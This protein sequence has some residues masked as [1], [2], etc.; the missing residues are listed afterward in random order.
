MLKLNINTSY[1][2]H[3]ILGLLVA[4][5]LVIFLIIIAPFDAAD[6]SM[7]IRL[8]LMPPYGIIL[9]ACYLPIIFFQ[10]LIYKK[11]ETW[12]L[13]LELLLIAIFY[14]LDFYFSFLYYRSGIVNGDWTF[15]QFLSGI[16]LPIV[17]ILS[18]ILFFGRWFI[19]RKKPEK[20]V[21]IKIVQAK[22]AHKII[23]KGENKLDALQIELQHLVCISSAQNYVEVFFLQN[24]ILQK[25]LLRTTLKKISLN[26]PELIQ[27]HRSH[28]VNPTHFVKWLNQNTIQLNDLEIPVSKNFKSNLQELI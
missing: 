1:R 14:L 9:F 17:I 7:K 8:I 23:L 15:I 18:T 11:I 10:N 4:I 12:N 28:L 25:K 24:E 20:E 21:E 13:L 2:A 22:P 5:W 19:A 26:A 6:V 27:V 16:Y 3:S